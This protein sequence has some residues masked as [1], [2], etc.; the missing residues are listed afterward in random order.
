MRYNTKCKLCAPKI[1]KGVLLRVRDTIVTVFYLL[2]A[3]PNNGG[4]LM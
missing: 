3:I 4:I 2:T 1:L